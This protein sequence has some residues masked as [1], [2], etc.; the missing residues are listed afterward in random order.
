MNDCCLTPNEQFI[1]NAMARVSCIQ[2]NDDDVRFAIDRYVCVDFIALAHYNSA[3][4]D[5]SLHSE[6]I[7]WFRTN[8][9]W[10]SL[11]SVA[12]FAEKQQIPILLCLELMI[13]GTRGEHSN[14]YTTDM[15]QLFRN[16]S[17]DPV[18]MDTTWLHTCYIKIYPSFFDLANKRLSLNNNCKSRTKQC[19]FIFKSFE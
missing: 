10:F 11:L 18:Y 9:S 2:W 6:A 17:I 8:Q 1:R 12:Y 14:Y 7:Y 5:M 13:Y 4:I 16:K 19:H 3:R 15:V